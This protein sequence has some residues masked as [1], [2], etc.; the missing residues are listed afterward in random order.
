[1]DINW[2]WNFGRVFNKLMKTST[3]IT[4]ERDTLAMLFLGTLN[5]VRNMEF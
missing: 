1:M 3:A 2:I 5:D 4:A